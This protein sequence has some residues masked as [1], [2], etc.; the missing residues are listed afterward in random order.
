MIF[1]TVG[2]QKFQFN[3]LLKKIDNLVEI[4]IIQ[5]EVI[6]QIGYSDYIPKNFKYK[7]FMDRDEFKYIL[8]ICDKVITHGGTGAIIGAVK[9]GKRVLAIPRLKEFGEHVDNHQLEIVSQFKELGFIET[10]DNIED[11]EEA[12]SYIDLIESKYY[13]SNTNTIIESIDRFMNT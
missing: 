1:L 5:E 10:V 3:R 9:K 13:I 12:L 8:D 7:Q 4:G 6:A 11:L 2:S